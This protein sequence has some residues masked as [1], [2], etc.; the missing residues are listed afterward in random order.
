M[1]IKKTKRKKKMNTRNFFIESIAIYSSIFLVTVI[2]Q[3]LI[4][5]LE[6]YLLGICLLKSLI[7]TIINTL[8]VMYGRQRAIVKKHWFLET[9]V[10]TVCSLPYVELTMLYL[11]QENIALSIKMFVA[12]VVIYF[13]F[14][15]FIKKYLNFTKNVINKIFERE[16]WLLLFFSKV[17]NRDWQKMVNIY[18]IKINMHIK[19]IY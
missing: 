16:E 8:A 6:L 9:L 17:K 13:I 1:E 19:Q 18:S 15:L 2:V 11:Y 7:T 10:Y 12:Y 4:I 14:G 3:G 5:Q